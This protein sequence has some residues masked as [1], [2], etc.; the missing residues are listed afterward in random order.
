MYY[1][2]I[3]YNNVYDTTDFIVLAN[4]AEKI[5]ELEDYERDY[6]KK[7]QLL[8]LYN[9]CLNVDDIGE[10]SYLIEYIAS[11]FEGIEKIETNRIKVM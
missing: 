3:F 6:V 2:T 11:T 7:E 8:E 1:K 10:H 5:I 4:Q 9:Y